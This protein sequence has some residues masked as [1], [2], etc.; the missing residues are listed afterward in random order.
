VSFKDEPIN[1]YTNEKVRRVLII[2]GPMI[3]DSIGSRGLSTNNR[4]WLSTILSKALSGHKL[5]FKNCPNI[6]DS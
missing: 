4:M 3:S 6:F 5:D 1:N 2:G